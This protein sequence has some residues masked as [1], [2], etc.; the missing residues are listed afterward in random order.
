MP[1]QCGFLKIPSIWQCYSLDWLKAS[2]PLTTAVNPL[3]ITWTP[4][5]RGR[6][7]PLCFRFLS[8][9][10]RPRAA[11]R[12]HACLRH[13]TALP[14]SQPAPRPGPRGSA[15]RRSARAVCESAS[16]LHRRAPAGLASVLWVVLRDSIRAP[17]GSLA[18][19]GPTPGK[20]VRVLPCRMTPFVE[21]RGSCLRSQ[22]QPPDRAGVSVAFLSGLANRQEETPRR[23][24]TTLIDVARSVSTSRR[25][26]LHPPTRPLVHSPT[27]SFIHSQALEEGEGRVFCAPGPGLRAGAG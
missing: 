27:H 26:A 15:A 25:R 23:E 9:A 2:T 13:D 10:S 5:E 3:A 11:A 7:W 6:D 1:Q 14:A 4:P 16:A 20:G 19:L 12:R 21:A 22:R 8:L 17:T 18:G 24:D